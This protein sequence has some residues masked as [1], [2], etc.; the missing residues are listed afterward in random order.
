MEKRFVVKRD[1]RWEPFSREKLVA[2]LVRS[3]LSREEAEEI[4]SLVEQRAPRVVSARELHR[5]VKRLLAARHPLAVKRYVLKRALMRL[6]PE[7]YPFEKYFARLLEA[8]GFEARTNLVVKGRCVEH[9]VD[10]E[11]VKDGRRYMVE[12]K[13]HNSPGIYTGLK[14]VLYV[15][16]RLRDLS[17]RFDEAWVATNTRFS[18]EAIQY[19][20]CAGVR[21]TAWGYPPGW[22]IQELVEGPG[23]YPVTVLEELGVDARR[24]LLSAGLVTLSD[25]VAA[26]PGRVAALLGWPLGAAERILREAAAVARAGSGKI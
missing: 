17:G 12:C 22:S 2:S 8:R 1:G 25:L 21:L 11:A 3:G 14:V 26:G 13:Y 4:A 19:A 18:V 15:R 20:R 23:L 7:G 6:G 5:I 10:V 9:E 24:R 16:E